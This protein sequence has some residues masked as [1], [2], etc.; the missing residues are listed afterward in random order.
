MTGLKI[1]NETVYV[2]YCDGHPYQGNGRKLVYTT[3]GAANGVITNEATDKL[4]YGLDE[5]YDL[6]HDE[7][8]KLIEDEKK[9]YTIVEYTP[10][11]T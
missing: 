8:N 2:I 1:K 3:K 4:R 5:F 6:T 10:K 9:K 7:R 11:G